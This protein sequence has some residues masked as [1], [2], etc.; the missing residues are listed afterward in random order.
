MSFVANH[1]TGLFGLNH[2]CIVNV[3]HVVCEKNNDDQVRAMPLF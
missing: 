2:S 3:I 1:E